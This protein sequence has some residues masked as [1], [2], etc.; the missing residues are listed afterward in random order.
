MSI[1]LVFMVKDSNG[2]ILG[3]PKPS[4]ENCSSR[5][6]CLSKIVMQ[7]M[8]EDESQISINLCSNWSFDEGKPPLTV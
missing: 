7:F 8:Y 1:E 2:Q 6:N 4:C 3:E 5:G